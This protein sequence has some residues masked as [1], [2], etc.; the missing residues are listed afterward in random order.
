MKYQSLFS[1][2][3]IDTIVVRAIVGEVRGGVKQRVECACSYPGI[4]DAE[5]TFKN[6]DLVNVTDPDLHSLTD[7]IFNATRQHSHT[8][9]QYVGS[10]C[11]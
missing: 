2:Q 3:C 1:R 8:E 11:I 5:P 4:G 6:T 7:Q 10:R 9:A